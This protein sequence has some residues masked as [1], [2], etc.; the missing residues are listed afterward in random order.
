MST[1]DRRPALYAAYGQAAEI[2]AGVRPNQL[3]APTPCPDFDVSALIDHLVGAGH[4]TAALGRGETPTPDEFPHIE[5]SDASQQLGQAR[6]Q[7]EEAWSDDERLLATVTMPWGETY[8]GATLVDMYLAE[9][10]AHA[11]DL[12]SATGQVDR[13]DIDLATTALDGARAMLKPE[14][15]NVMGK[16]NPYGTEVEAPN[17]GTAWERFAAF[18]GRNPRPTSG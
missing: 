18:M 14:Y 17:N 12:A 2:V 16:G 4:R 8:T 13:L 9:L 15:R 10:A 7:A 5:L 1:I 3:S 6:T 11:W